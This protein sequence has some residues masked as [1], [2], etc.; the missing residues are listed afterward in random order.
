MVK[1]KL[2]MELRIRVYDANNV[3]VHQA[4]F[5][6]FIFLFKLLSDGFYYY[7]YAILS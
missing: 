5:E 4:V 3:Y 6:E 7:Y 2:G 1:V